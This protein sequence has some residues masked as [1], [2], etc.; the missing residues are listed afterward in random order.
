MIRLIFFAT[1]DDALPI[2]EGLR[3]E[4][5]IEV[6][7]IVTRPPKPKGRGL[8]VVS[9]A[10]QSW[11]EKHNIPVLTPSSLRDDTIEEQLKTFHADMFAIF[12]YGSLIPRSLLALPP[13]GTVNI[14]PSLL[15]RYRGAAPISAALLNGDE[16]TGISYMLLDE[17]MDTGPLLLQEK[18]AITPEDTQSLLRE[19]LIQRA[20]VRFPDVLKKYQQGTLVPVPQSAE[21]IS[22]TRPLQKADGRLDLT[23]PA[24]VLERM[25]R[26]YTGWPGTFVEWNGKPLRIITA[27]IAESEKKND[28]GVAIRI[29]NLPALQTGD[30][31]L[32]LDE[33]QL[34][35][36]QKTDGA[37]F[38]N[39]NAGFTGSRLIR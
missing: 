15:P 26:A 33:V 30:G 5:E 12:A 16:E 32:V 3:K 2:A 22:I 29:G 21:G 7:A 37:S 38:L 39:G 35:G 8:R 36:K 11:G 23:Q 4:A 27:H 10:L 28:V 24:S 6:A 14:H 18:V 34:P 19:R 31:L 25:V 17:G 9:S 13:K 20:A 1:P